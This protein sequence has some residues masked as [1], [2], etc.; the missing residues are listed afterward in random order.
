MPKPLPRKKTPFK[1]SQI[2]S[3]KKFKLFTLK[4]IIVALVVAIVAIGGAAAFT[5]SQMNQDSR[6]AAYIPGES[7]RSLQEGDCRAVPGC[8]WTPTQ[9]SCTNY[10]GSSCPSEC[11]VR[12]EQS[13]SGKYMC[14]PIP[15]PLCN[16]TLGDCIDGRQGCSLVTSRTCTGGTFTRP[17]AGSCSGTPSGGGGNPAPSPS[18]VGGGGG[19]NPAPS[20]SPA[21]GGGGGGGGNNPPP[22]GNGGGGGQSGTI[23]K[24]FLDVVTGSFEARGWACDPDNYQQPLA[25]HFYVDDTPGRGTFI[26]QTTANVAREAAVGAECGGRSASG[27]TFQIP[28]QHLTTTTAQDRKIFAYAIDIGPGANAN[29]NRHLA[30]SP[31]TFRT[32]AVDNTPPRGTYSSSCSPASGQT[33]GDLRYELKVTGTTPKNIGSI[34]YYLGFWGNR[35]SKALTDDFLGQPTW[36]STCHDQQWCGYWLKQVNDPNPG[37]NE[38][39]S[40]VWDGNHT[41]AYKGGGIGRAVTINELAT[42]IQQLKASGKLPA[43]YKVAV[44]AEYRLPDGSRYKFEDSQNT[45]YLDIVPTACGAGTTTPG[46][47]TVR[48]RG[49]IGGGGY[50]VMELR[51]KGKKWMSWTV[52]NT[53]Q[54]YTAEIPSGATISDM[55]LHFINDYYDAAA[56]QDRNLEVD[57]LKFGNTVYQ[58]EAATTYSVGTWGGGSCAGGNKQS[59]WLHCNGY[60]S[61]AG[62]QAPPAP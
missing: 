43:D 53:M 15:A 31:L 18:P 35:H 42:K 55:T 38:T 56:N 40:W 45:Q 3:Y 19:G 22:P 61:Y 26:G 50:P 60:F 27:F 39:I 2:G 17:G 10:E 12:T 59:Q 29:T 4:N 28:P 14:Q 13:C 47:I 41:I 23:P 20:P 49:T 34:V 9:Y 37:A 6:S 52:T 1:R 44:H 58:S 8:T 7:C 33:M 46:V 48:A 24:G 62:Q 25:I 30:K 11:T 57:Y 54:D 16:C 32:T 21:S 36:S 5:L 51:H